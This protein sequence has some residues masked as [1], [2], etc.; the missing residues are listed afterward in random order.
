[1]RIIII[2]LLTIFTGIQP[3]F[4]TRIRWGCSTPILIF[5]ILFLLIHCGD[6]IYKPPKYA[7]M[8]MFYILNTYLPE[9][10]ARAQRQVQ[11]SQPNAIYTAFGGSIIGCISNKVT[12]G[13]IYDSTTGQSIVLDSLSP[14]QS[15]ICKCNSG[16]TNHF[17]WERGAIQDNPPS[18]ITTSRIFNS[19]DSG[20]TINDALVYKTHYSQPDNLYCIPGNCG[21]SEYRYQLLKIR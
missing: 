9:Q 19:Y 13:F 6:S 5:Y 10:S 3:L 20:H 8:T 4:A 12:Q 16:S 21:F 14:G 7:A 17:S 11:C 2:S 18:G 15:L 1:M